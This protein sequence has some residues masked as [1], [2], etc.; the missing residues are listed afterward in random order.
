MLQCCRR[1]ARVGQVFGRCVIHL[2]LA[3]VAQVVLSD[4]IEPSIELLPPVTC[5][6]L[7]SDYPKTPHIHCQATVLLF[8]LRW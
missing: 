8:W 4:A 6:S 7:H 1:G 2:A 3:V 5:V